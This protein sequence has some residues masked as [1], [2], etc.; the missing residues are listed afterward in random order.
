[1]TIQVPLSQGKVALISDHCFD[2]LNQWKWTASFRKGHWYAIRMEGWPI[3]KVIQMHRIITSAKEGDEVDHIDNDGLNNQDENL[4]ICTKSENMRNR[5]KNKNNTTGYKG[6][7]FVEDRN[8]YH[9][10]ITINRKHIYLGKSLTAEGAAH[11]YDEGAKKYHGKFANLN[12]K[13]S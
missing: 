1:M 13:E 9:A 8:E 3:Q 11:I 6:V 12:F 7:S 4:R 5:G 10:N 2:Y